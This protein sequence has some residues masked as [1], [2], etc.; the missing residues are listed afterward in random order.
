MGITTELMELPASQLRVDPRVQRII[1]PRRVTKIAN[2]WND[3]MVGV[4]T[5][6]HR[7]PGLALI[8]G[9]AAEEWV[10]LDGQ[11][12]WQALKQV[13][14]A[15]TTSCTMTA[16]VHTGLT[17]QEEAAIFL[18]HNDR[19][20]I[21]PLDNFRISLIA[22]EEWAE[23]IRDIAARYRWAVSGTGDGSQRTFQ[24]IGAAKRIYFSDENGSTLDR[25]FAVIDAAWPRDRGTVCGETLHGI[26]TLYASHGGLDTSG[27]VT[28]LGK[29]GFNK[30]YSSVRD[31]Y[32]THPSMSLAAAAYARTVEIYNSGRRTKRVE[33]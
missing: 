18:Q 12:R 8:G 5:V 3:L 30:F 31:T 28:K 23:G 33:M 24:A 11:T 10:I 4:I 6:S 26:G 21:T 22:E 7:V 20:A 25:T 15:E 19:K 27:F 9:E 17:L 32:R 29:L 16:Q 1:D 2:N 13:C 14:G